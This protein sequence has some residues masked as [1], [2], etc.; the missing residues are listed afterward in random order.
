[1]SGDERVAAYEWLRAHDAALEE[2]AAQLRARTAELEGHAAQWHVANERLAE[3]K[4]QLQEENARLRDAVADARA[5]IDELRRQVIGWKG[6]RLTPE[7]QEHL[8]QKRPDLK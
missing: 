3:E 7:P 2:E 6:D 5:L 4:A 1:M 8:K